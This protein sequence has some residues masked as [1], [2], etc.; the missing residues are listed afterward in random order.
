MWISSLIIFYMI[1]N[2]TAG[3]E[4]TF[5]SYVQLAGTIV[6]LFGTAVYNGSVPLPGLGDPVPL[7][8]TLLPSGVAKSSAASLRLSGAFQNNSA[9][10]QKTA[11]KEAK[12]LSQR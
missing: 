7:K 3:E 8:E 9:L 2:G 4:W 11:A 5:A 6:L 10:L 12:R 1:S